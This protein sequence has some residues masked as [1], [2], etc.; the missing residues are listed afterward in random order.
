MRLALLGVA[1]GLSLGCGGQAPP[2]PSVPANPPPG[3][4]VRYV[5][6]GDSRDDASHVLPWA[7]R[8]AKARGASGFFF[9]G[10]ME[11]TPQLDAHFANEL[12]LLD[13]IPLYPALGNHEVRVFGFMPLGKAEAERAFRRRFLG[14][15][16]TPVTNSITDKVVYSVDLPGGLHFI[17]LDNVSQNGFGPAQL[18]WLGL[19]LEQASQNASVRHIVIGMHKPLAHNGVATHG[20]DSDGAQAIADSD[21]ALALFMKFKVT[22]ILASHVHEFAHFSQAGIDSYITGGLGAPLDNSGPEH[23]FHHFLQ[24]DLDGDAIKVSVVRFDG[25]PTFGPSSGEE[26]PD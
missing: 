18:A 26:A 9:L 10:D 25:K 11:L 13:P 5:V 2:P 15:S 14:T 22:L 21:A 16:R 7:F 17:A 1:L 12:P 24:L 19:D 6:G 4:V 20:M 3:S 8:E 23:A